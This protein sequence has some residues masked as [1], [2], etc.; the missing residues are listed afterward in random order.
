M[1]YIVGVFCVIYAAVPSIC[2]YTGSCLLIDSFVKDIKN[3]L[4]IL[5]VKKSHS[6]K[7]DG[8]EFKVHLFKIVQVYS[9]VKELSKPQVNF[10]LLE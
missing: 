7:T 4:N 8:V 1:F 10:V 5:R 3:D 2:F 6:H 9:E